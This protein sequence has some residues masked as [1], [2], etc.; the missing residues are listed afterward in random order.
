MTDK[1]ESDLPTEDDDDQG[2]VPEPTLEDP[3]ASYDSKVRDKAQLRK[4]MPH[5]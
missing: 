3:E 1:K 5:L 4:E 2:D